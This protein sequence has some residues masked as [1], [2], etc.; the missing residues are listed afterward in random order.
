MDTRLKQSLINGNIVTGIVIVMVL[1]VIALVAA[2]YERMSEKL[3]YEISAVEHHVSLL[4]NRVPV[5]GTGNPSTG[6]IKKEFQGHT[7]LFTASPPTEIVVATLATTEVKAMRIKAVK[8]KK[9][10]IVKPHPRILKAKSIPDAM[11]EPI[12]TPSGE[13]IAIWQTYC[14][15]NKDGHCADID[16]EHRGK[17]T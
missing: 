2:S 11:S 5:P 15:L 6:S 7:G 17:D 14:A 12:P 3:G 13:I 4:K 10:T 8:I 16:G 9:T 1:M